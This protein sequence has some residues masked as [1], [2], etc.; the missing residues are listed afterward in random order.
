MSRPLVYV[1]DDEPSI[2]LYL[3]AALRAL[4]CDVRLFSGVVACVE[5]AQDAR[6][7]LVLMDWLMPGLSQAPALDALRAAGVPRIV[8]CSALALP[9]DVDRLMAAGP[10][11]FLAKPC[12]LEDLEDMLARWLG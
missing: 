3:D 11:G 7:E 12:T 1:I 2:R 9:D 4:G 8:V 10:D 6:P 5:A